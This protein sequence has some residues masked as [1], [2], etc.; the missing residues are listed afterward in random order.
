MKKIT[1]FTLMSLVSLNAYAETSDLCPGEDGYY[2]TNYRI[3]QNPQAGGFV[4]Y[5]ATI[6]DNT[7]I[8]IGRKAAVCG[9]AIISDNAQVNGSAIVRGNA[10][11]SGSSIITENVIIEGD[12]EIS[13]KSVITGAGT[14][15]S[16]S[17]T[18]AKKRLGNSSPTNATPSSTST[19]SAAE[20][21]TK[22]QRYVND[23]AS[24]MSPP[25]GSF[26]DGSVTL[27][28]EISFSS[29]AC[30]LTIKKNRS[31]SNHSSFLGRSV[32][33]FNIGRA[34][35]IQTRFYSPSLST[36]NVQLD[37]ANATRRYWRWDGSEETRSPWI[38]QSVLYNSNSVESIESSSAADSKVISELL[39]KLMNACK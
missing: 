9:Y 38:N 10:Q 33:S 3:T 18:D 27:T 14:L 8:V 29:G 15:R 31:G 32:T 36:S 25:D 17:Y 39:T 2:Y 34:T 5:T 19:A 7:R 37:Q 16:G 35:S 11:V 24:R 1:I 12:A 26:Y 13:G 4:A 22:L 28:Q 30:Q 6:A 20:L 21:A 23:H